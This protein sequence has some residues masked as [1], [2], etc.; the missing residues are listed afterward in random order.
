MLDSMYVH[1]RHRNLVNLFL[2]W[3]F[4]VVFYH[5]LQ[6]SYDSAHLSFLLFPYDQYILILVLSEN[7]D[8]SCKQK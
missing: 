8:S 1:L 2:I 5:I 3:F 7:N 4:D 6:I